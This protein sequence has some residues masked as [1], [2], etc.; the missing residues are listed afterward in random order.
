MVCNNCGTEVTQT[1]NVIHVQPVKKNDLSIAGF[2]LSFFVSIA[3]L[4]CSIL[5]LIQCKQRNEYGKG[6]AI[7]GIVISSASIFASVTLVIA[8]LFGGLA[9]G[10]IT[11]IMTSFIMI[12]YGYL[13]KHTDRDVSFF[14]SVSIISIIMNLC[15]NASG[16]FG[17]SWVYFAIALL[18]FG[19]GFAVS[20]SGSV[21]F[22]ASSGPWFKKQFSSAKIWGFN[23][24]SA[25]V[26]PAGI[27]LFFVNYKKNRE[28]ACQCGK[29]AL[30]GILLWALI[31][32]AILGLVL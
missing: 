4:I 32:W 16:K 8:L 9:L 21:S 15:T 30:W 18:F 28:F 14:M 19:L 25:V 13:A 20:A 24:L 10:I 3:G 1:E 6:F 11:L 5:G 2:V 29:A 26:F 7:A 12:Y 17:L 23:V 22:F 27:V 31:L